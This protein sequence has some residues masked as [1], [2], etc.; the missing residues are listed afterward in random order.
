[1]NRLTILVSPQGR[2]VFPG[3]SEFLDFLGDPNPD[4]DAEAFAVKN[5]GFRQIHDD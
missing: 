1:M 4:Y 3:S 2:W 5:M